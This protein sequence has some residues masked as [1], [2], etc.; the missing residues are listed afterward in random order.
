M[1]ETLAKVFPVNFAKFL[2]ANCLQNTSGQILLNVVQITQHSSKNPTHGDVQ[3]FCL[4][5]WIC[6]K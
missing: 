5:S 4:K 2:Q 6:L 3:I 1:S